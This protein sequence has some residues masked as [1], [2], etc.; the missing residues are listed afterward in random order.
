MVVNQCCG[1][2]HLMK[3]ISKIASG[4]EPSA[5]LA[6]SEL[7][8]ELKA[9]GVDVIGF[10]AGEPDFTTPDN[11]KQAGIKAIETDKSYYTA[12]SGILPLRE[13]ICKYINDIFGVQYEPS[14][15]CVSSG[16]KHIIFISLQVLLDPGDEVILPAPYW[17]TYAE[18]IKMC[19]AVP[20]ILDTTE[21][22]RFKITPEQLESAITDKTK[23]LILTNPSNPTGMLYNEDELKAIGNV[24]IKN[25]LYLIADEIY[26]TLVYNGKFVSAAAI[27]P[28]LKERTIVINGVSK[29]Y[30]MTGWRIG[31][32]AA[33]KQII[34]AMANYLSHST[35]NASNVA[36]YAALEAYSCDQE[37]VKKM[38][39]EFAKRRQYFIDRVS[40]MDK[41]S[42]LEPDGAFYIF[43]NV[44][45][46]F[47]T[48]LCGE[49]I[50]SGSDFSQ[51]LLKHGL[52]A[53]VPGI[54]FGND[55][56]VRWSYA[57]SMENITEGLN[58]LEKFLNS[59][60]TA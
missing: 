50:N 56:Y 13:A 49:K 55:N 33:N 25:D 27:S 21:E 54:A 20:V 53:T 59:E 17:V 30:A 40:K 6:I 47:G 41:V 57:T 16:A 32:A 45:K 39:I 46:T 29:T 5:T 12:T 11:I 26:A 1:G 58:R 44:S 37:S 22:T 24:I 3:N 19:G 4:I 2:E 48:E 8:K 28:E 52:V 43:M 15:I 31:Y 34:S 7:S 36:Q 14:N 10:G 42:C 51:A 18:A 9:K 23:C 38:N 60:P 35:G